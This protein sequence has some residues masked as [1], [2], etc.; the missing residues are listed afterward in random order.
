MQQAK[1]V[2][3][4]CLPRCGKEASEHSVNLTTGVLSRPLALLGEAAAAETRYF[5]VALLGW[6]AENPTSKASRGG[7]SLWFGPTSHIAART[8]QSSSD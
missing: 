7:S 8:Q 6:E 3:S 5:D 4:N 2:A 1:A